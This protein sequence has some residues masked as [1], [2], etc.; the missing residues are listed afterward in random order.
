M[1]F[2]HKTIRV[3]GADSK[4][5]LTMNIFILLGIGLLGFGVYQE[6]TKKKGAGKVENTTTQQP[7]TT[8]ATPIN[9][10]EQPVQK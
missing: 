7:T 5:G 4:K 1:D 2:S 8:T 3:L 9:P 6:T 10:V